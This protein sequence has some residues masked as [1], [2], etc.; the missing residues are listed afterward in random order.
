MEIKIPII[1]NNNEVKKIIEKKNAFEIIYYIKYQCKKISK[2]NLVLLANALVDLKDGD[3]I[4]DLLFNTPDLDITPISDILINGL[5]DSKDT[6][7]I[8]SACIHNNISDDNR[9]ILVDALIEMKSEYLYDI[10]CYSDYPVDKR[11]EILNIIIE[12]EDTNKIYKVMSEMNNIDVDLEKKF[13]DIL[14]K[15]KMYNSIKKLYEKLNVQTKKDA[16]EAIENSND[17]KCIYEFVHDVEI[18]EEQI[19]KLINAIVKTNNAKYIYKFI[20]N[21]MKNHHIKPNYELLLE[22]ALLKTKD[23]IYIANYIYLKRSKLLLEKI[24]GDFYKFIDYCYLNEKKLNFSLKDLNA[25]IGEESYKY[26]DDNI[27]NYLNRN[28]LNVSKG[29]I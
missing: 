16:F 10:F 27:D 14:I 26:V 18:S 13:M 5:I 19:E 29:G 20:E 25:W 15:K 9:R 21:V 3:K 22:E 1:S 4:Y 23:L 8:A 11:E 6:Y 17:P 28:Y 12:L 7:C 2:N 24:F